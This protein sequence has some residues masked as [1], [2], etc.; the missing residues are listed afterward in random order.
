MLEKLPLGVLGEKGTADTM[1]ILSLGCSLT[2]K[3][4]RRLRCWQ[5]LLT[6]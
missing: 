5:A 4:S 3:K 2:V 6:A 1:P